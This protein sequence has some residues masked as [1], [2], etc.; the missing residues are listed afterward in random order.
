MGNEGS[1]S[2]RLHP[3]LAVPAVIV[4]L[5]AMTVAAMLTA[6]LGMRPM[7]IASELALAS[8]AL[9]ALAVARGRA[10]MGLVPVPPRV[11]A[12][13]LG[14]GA[15]L[16]AAS[17]GLL[18]LQYAV[19]TPP[20]GYL[21]EFQRL[22]DMLRP[23]GP[24]DAALSVLAI[25]VA[26]AVCEE[27]LFRGLVLQSLLPLLRP[28]VAVV[29]SAVLFGAIHID[30]SGS[31]ATLYRVPFAIVV[32]VGFAFLRLRSGS[33]IPSMVAHAVVNTITFAAALQES[34]AAT[35][36]SPRPLLG[37][38]LLLAGTTALVWLLSLLRPAPISPSHERAHSL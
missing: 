38:T 32:G 17:L 3:I 2:G 8:P 36:P 30:F 37:V 35:L 7:L 5:A 14:A 9:I 33:L 6:G 13:A 11:I 27:L 26:P 28:A 19:W 18:E 31:G 16:W 25:A 1:T 4:G 20:P 23:Q 22:H 21:Q 10:A 34:P 29:A 15:A 12:I 24:V